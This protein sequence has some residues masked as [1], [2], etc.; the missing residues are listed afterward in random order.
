MRTL[1]TAAAL[2]LVAGSALGQTTRTN[3][4]A[5]STIPTIPSSPSTSPTSP[6]YSAT[7]PTSPCYS[8]TNPGSPY[9]SATTPYSSTTPAGS[10]PN[11]TNQ[12][13]PVHSLTEDQAKSRIEAKGYSNV[14]GLRRD[15]G[16]WR[17][18]AMMQDGKSVDIILDLQGNI[19]SK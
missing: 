15:H 19:V 13:A 16:I 3:P 1:L 11:T 18:K 8:A 14:S 5:S 2:A 10:S 7:N 6:C 12:Q 17:G 4:S 9:Y